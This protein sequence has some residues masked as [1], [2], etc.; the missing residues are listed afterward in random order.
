MKRRVLFAILMGAAAIHL[1]RTPEYDMDLLGYMG[2]ALL[3]RTNDVRAIHR[4]VYAEVNK[5][6]NAKA[7]EGESGDAEQNISRKARFE[8][9]ETFGE[10]L[11][12]FAVRPAYNTLLYAMSP[13]GMARAAG[14]ISAASW[15]F[16]G[17]LL[18][19]WTDQALYSLLVM[20]T[21]PLMSIG[22]STMSD[23]FALLVT[24]SGVYLIFEKKRLVPGLVLL[25]F[26]IFA[27]TDSVLLVLPIL[28]VLWFHGE[29][30]WW[31][32]AT[33]GVVSM[34]VVLTIN[35][36]AGDY[37]LQTLYYR[38]FVTQ[39]L[40]PAEVP[41]HFSFHEYLG[42]FR[43]GI[44]V[45]MESFFLPFALLGVL[46]AKKWPVLVGIGLVFTALHYIALPN[47]QERWFVA[48][49]LLFAVAAVRGM[50]SA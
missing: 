20:L 26:G 27:R 30:N 50:R 19:Q 1:Y 40:A 32:A 41:V 38:N 9:W 7:L 37:G 4:Q 8:R 28:A 2:N 29:I 18:F 6:P 13:M 43:K 24:M 22:R 33:L 21:A 12:F 11:P 34:A 25:L 3:Y 35:H 44:T 5:L 47:Y 46:G 23:G 42:A 16:L 10:F 48:S 45:T 15:L 36:S 39:P 31:T 49:Y 17:W 14:L